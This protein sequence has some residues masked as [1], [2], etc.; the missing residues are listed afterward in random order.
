MK[1]DFE[2]NELNN[3]KGLLKFPGN[4]MKFLGYVLNLDSAEIVDLINNSSAIEE[5]TLKIIQPLLSHYSNAQPV[6]IL[7]E[8]VKFVD[9]PGG[10]AYEKAFLQ[11]VVLPISEIFG[12]SPEKIIDRS[13]IMGGFSLPYG[14]CSVQIPAFPRIPLTVVIW[15]SGEFPAS[16]NLF[17]DKSACNYLPTEDLAVLAELMVTRLIRA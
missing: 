5:T 8:L 7:K 14:D 4:K 9:L 1:L 2:G 15:K 6:E 16:A 3:L 12:D 11:R 10:Y 17:Y 13:K